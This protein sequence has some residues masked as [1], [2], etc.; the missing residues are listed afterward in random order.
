LH[1]ILIH[2]ARFKRLLHQSALVLLG[3][4]ICLDDK[5]FYDRA[6]E[7]YESRNKMAHQGIMPGGEVTPYSGYKQAKEAI[8]CAIR[9]VE[10]F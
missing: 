6:I 5:T 4:S 9:L 7:V 3:K 2:N 10:W 8:Q 1:E